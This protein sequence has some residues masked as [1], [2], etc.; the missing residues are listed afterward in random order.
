[1]TPA[2]AS[3]Y[4]PISARL[5]GQVLNATGRLDDAI[6]G[7]SV[8]SLSG[9]IL[10]Q[11]LPKL[12]PHSAPSAE[13]VLAE[14][15]GHLNAQV[16]VSSLQAVRTS[17]VAHITRE[18]IR[19]GLELLAD[20]GIV[21]LDDE[22]LTQRNYL[23]PEGSWDT[24]FLE[25]HR[26]RLTKSLQRVDLP[27]GERRLLTTEQSRVFRDVMAQPDDHMHVQ[28]YA[29]TGKSYVIKSLLWGLEPAGASVLVLAE[30]QRQLNALL[31]PSS[32]MA[33]VQPRT[34]ARLISEMVPPDLVDPSKRRLIRPNYSPVPM[35][36]EAMARHLGVQ[37]SGGFSPVAI[38]ELIRRTVWWF[39]RSGDR[40]IEARHLPATDAAS[41]DAT[42]RQ[43]VLHHATELWKA[44]LLP[45]SRDFQPPARGY[46]RLKWAA[47]NGWQIPE[48][49]THVLIDECH[50]LPKPMLQILDASPQAVISLGDEYQNL[51]GRP[52]QRS[53]IV[54]QRTVTHSVRSGHL[55]ESVVNPI[56]ATHPART[57]LPFHGNPLSKTHIEYY[58]KAEVP[59]QPTAILVNDTWAL[60]EWTQRV[61][62]KHVEFRLLS[63]R[64]NLDIFVE[65]CIE[66]HQRGTRPRHGELFRFASWDALARDHHDN[67]GFQRIER[68]LRDGYSMAHWN[69]TRAK[70]IKP[71][72]PGYAVGLIEDVRNRDLDA[73]MLVPEIID[74]LWNEKRGAYAA[75]SSLLYV[76]VTRARHRLIVPERLRHW[77]EANSA[78]SAGIA[79]QAQIERLMA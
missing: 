12:K 29:G 3:L 64:D 49:Y 67:R 79:A 8:A 73:V 38:V 42:T 19:A 63:S 48:R 24:S 33:H 20:F 35:Q 27:S 57:K 15:V 53:N 18:K 69:K 47:L 7:L 37:H 65:D 16:K 10:L 75:A 74:A 36:D 72:A 70:F 26:E 61:A 66:L 50:D 41:L 44:I 2:N 46:H 39:C 14:T 17:A 1:M 25:R 78:T 52:Q 68:M 77:I 30:R 45:P 22:A 76:A 4:L 62:A 58:D 54:R 55:I 40:E 23:T 28:G 34:F 11:F 9:L 6:A 5:L 13:R 59:A 60:F 43:V 56:I 21:L 71:S 51:Q 32:S 31:P